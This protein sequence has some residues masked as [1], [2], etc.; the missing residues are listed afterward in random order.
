M[1]R[2]REAK[3]QNSSPEFSWG[4]SFMEGIGEAKF[5]NSSP[6]FSWGISF[7]ERI[8]EVNIQNDF[9]SGLLR[10]MI[11]GMIRDIKATKLKKLHNNNKL[12]HNNINNRNGKGRGIFDLGILFLFLPCEVV[13][14]LCL[15]YP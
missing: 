15:S 8:R 11:N 1:E 4:I 5:Q 7:M 9:V 14:G 6:E 3:F 2:I 10:A 13:W 12:H